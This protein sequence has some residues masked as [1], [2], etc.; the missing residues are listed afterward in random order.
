MLMRFFGLTDKGISR[1][2]N[3]DSFDIREIPSKKCTVCVLCDGMGGQ[4]SGNYASELAR[5]SFLD[6][7]VARLTSRTNKSPDP[8]QVLVNGALEANSV[9]FQYSQFTEEYNGMGS[10]L[11][12]GIVYDNGKVF[13]VNVGDSRAYLI[14]P[15]SGTVRQITKDHSLVEMWVSAGIITREEARKN[16][17]RN[18]I[19]RSIGAEG[20]VESDTFEE[21][22]K[23]NEML[24]L[25]SDGVSNYL[26]DEDLLSL[27]K[28]YSEPDGLCL[29]IKEVVYSRGAG[30]NLTA[31]AVVK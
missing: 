19:T 27:A 4:N 7:V 26:T 28:E 11:V 16:R 10:T 29:R 20:T 23:N 21:Y 13:I 12:G 25:C 30:D 9:V 1:A 15:K 8:C 18:I 14:S 5:R 31:V 22:L 3:Q 6:F 24:L 17:N 2:E